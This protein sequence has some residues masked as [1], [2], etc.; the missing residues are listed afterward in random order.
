M[1]GS[2][3]NLLKFFSV[4]ALLAANALPAYASDDAQADRQAPQNI[5]VTFAEQMLG[6]PYK[7]GGHSLAGIDCSG[8]VDR[9]YRTA[10]QMILPRTVKE[11]RQEGTR[12]KGKEPEIGD[13]LFFKFRGRHGHVG[14][15]A[16]NGTFLH[17]STSEGVIYSSLTDGFWNKRL[18]EVRRV[19]PEGSPMLTNAN[20]TSFE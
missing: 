13:L 9:F 10:Y 2:F 15:Y 8:L 6:T 14:I 7:L 1:K 18:I 4:L 3:Q 5:L 19:P 20:L 12:V 17:A 11:L 16:G